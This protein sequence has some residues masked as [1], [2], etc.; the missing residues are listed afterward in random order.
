MWSA[1]KARFVRS[2]GRVV[3]DA[4]GG[5]SHSESQGYGLLLAYLA[6]DR[7][8]FETIFD[9][10]PHR[11]PD[12]RRRARRVA[13]GPGRDAARH[14]HQQRQRR[15]HPDRLCARPRRLGL[16]RAG[17]PDRGARDR[18]GGRRE[19][20]RAQQRSGPADAGRD[21]L[22]GRNDR[23]DGPVV[24]P[25]YWVFEAFPVLARLAPGD[26]L[27]RCRRSRALR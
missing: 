10:H 2:E 26:G 21:G 27:G 24:N 25:S 16:A 13:L 3:D 12:P 1:Y 15:R 19:G 14:R 5:I 22:F 11:A 20:G 18:Q 8:A 17:L 9:L 7:V 6:G 23:A 4:N